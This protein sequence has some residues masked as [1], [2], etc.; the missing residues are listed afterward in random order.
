LLNI[1]AMGIE[2]ILQESYD[3]LYGARPVRR[4]VEKKVTT[5]LSRWILGGDLKDHSTVTLS[6]ADNVMT[7]AAT[8]H[9]LC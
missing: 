2:Y 9:G 3:P 7:F 6:S 8:P 5:M 1:D 4:F